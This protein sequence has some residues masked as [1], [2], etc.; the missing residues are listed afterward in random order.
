MYIYIYIYICIYI[1]IYYIIIS[2]ISHSPSSSG[3]FS[4][5]IPPRSLNTIWKTLISDISRG[6]FWNAV[7]YLAISYMLN[8]DGHLMQVS[9]VLEWF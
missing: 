3:T 7:N 5:P 9:Y 6:F 4:T 2:K 1:Y 8:A